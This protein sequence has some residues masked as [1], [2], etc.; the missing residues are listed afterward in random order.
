MA[1]SSDDSFVLDKSKVIADILKSRYGATGRALGELTSSVADKLPISTVLGLRRLAEIRNKVAKDRQP[2]PVRVYK[3]DVDR[4]YFEQLCTEVEN[5]LNAHV[6][7]ACADETSTESSPEINHERVALQAFNGLFVSSNL[8][9]NNELVADRQ[10]TEAWEIFDVFWLGDDKVAFRACN[11]LFVMANLDE[12][13]VLV[14]NR[15]DI[16]GWETFKIHY[17]ASGKVALQAHNGLFVSAKLH[18]QCQL[19]ADRSDVEGWES[20]TLMFV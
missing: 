20:F 18:E 10:L 9:L 2:F 4:S 7:P 17:L 6:A 5:S 14:A 12:N 15:P 1:N 8:H 19:V 3:D 16:Q 11:N 13:G